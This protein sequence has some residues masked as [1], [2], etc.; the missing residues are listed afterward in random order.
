[1]TE[2]PCLLSIDPSLERLTVIEHGRVWDGQP[3]FSQLES[4]ERIQMLSEDGR[5][6]A[7]VAHEPFDIDLDA[8]TDTELWEGPKFLVP[9]LGLPPSSIGEILLT[10]RARYRPDEPTADVAYFH[11]ATA[12][13]DPEEA[14]FLW[15]IVIEAGDMK[16]H[17]DYGYTLLDLGRHHEAYTHLRRYTEL[18]PLNSWAWC[19]F[20]K[21][22]EAIDDR[23]G[24]TE[25][26]REAILLERDGADETDAPELLDAMTPGPVNRDVEG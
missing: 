23:D 7:F 6:V 13:D 16:G 17:F 4:E 15:R 12:A 21:A 9:A 22:C 11:L 14:L 3:D 18:T 26:Y 19:W 24:A 2:I 1:M 10:V 25:A 8:V 20:G 5:T